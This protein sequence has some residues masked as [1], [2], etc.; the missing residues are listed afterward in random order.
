MIEEGGK[1]ASP[2]NTTFDLD[3][4]KDF[5]KLDGPLRGKFLYSLLETI[6]RL[7]TELAL[8]AN[9]PIR[10]LPSIYFL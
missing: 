5:K 2:A 1:P 10:L 3:I 4:L 8:A 7:E 9:L 6:K